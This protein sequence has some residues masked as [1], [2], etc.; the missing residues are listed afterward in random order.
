MALSK[1]A[2]MP[3]QIV[4]VRMNELKLLCEISRSTFYDTFSAFNK[5]EDM[6]HF[7]QH[8]FNEQILQHEMLQQC[9]HFFFAKDDNTISGYIKLSSAQSRH[10][11]RPALEIS[12]VY[13]IKEKLGSGLGKAFIEFSKTFA[14]NMNLKTLYLGVWEHNIRA[15]DFYKKFGFEKFD[16]Q[17]FMVGNDAQTDWLMKVELD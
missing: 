17:I 16:E 4:P 14:Q 8:S 7:L 15:I 5:K 3:L 10:F 2:F 1:F 9:N 12:R 6:D 11:D 13:V